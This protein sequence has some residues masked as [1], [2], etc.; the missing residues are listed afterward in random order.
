MTRLSPGLQQISLDSPGLPDIE[1][2]PPGGIFSH[3]NSTL[4]SNESSL[5]PSDPIFLPNNFSSHAYAG[6]LELNPGLHALP[7]PSLPPALPDALPIPNEMSDMLDQVLSSYT[8][9]Q[10]PPQNSLWNDNI[11]FE[12][13]V[14]QML[15]P[16]KP[17]AQPQ[18]HSNLASGPGFLFPPPFPPAAAASDSAQGVQEESLSALVSI[19]ESLRGASAADRRRHQSSD[20]HTHTQHSHQSSGSSIG[21]LPPLLQLCSIA[22][23]VGPPANSG[24]QYAQPLTYAVPGSDFVGAHGSAFNPMYDSVS[25]RRIAELQMQLASFSQ[26]FNGQSSG[27]DSRDRTDLMHRPI[28]FGAPVESLEQPVPKFTA[29]GGESLNGFQFMDPATAAAFGMTG[30]LQMP[31]ASATASANGAYSFS[32]GGPNAPII[33]Q[34]QHAYIN[35]ATSSP[36]ALQHLASV[37]QISPYAIPIPMPQGLPPPPPYEPSAL[38]CNPSAAT[39]SSGANVI[40]AELDASNKV[41]ST[42]P[43]RARSHHKKADGG[44]AGA[45]NAAASSQRDNSPAA[46]ACPAPAKKRRV[47]VRPPRG[48]SASV[49][50]AS[51]QQ[52]EGD[53]SAEGTSTEAAAAVVK[54]EP[55]SVDGAAPTTAL[56]NANGPPGPSAA[57]KRR[58]RSKARAPPPPS[59]FAKRYQIPRLNLLYLQ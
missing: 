7:D 6:E 24:P 50:P 51:S 39:S 28:S 26:N 59:P 33:I 37:P 41:S 3:I 31:G 42:T 12:E 5:F 10:N 22:D 36:V 58:R 34:P 21:Q 23:Q 4:L 16:F 8:L 19:D 14:A 30:P 55:I 17:T 46:D 29:A 57:N 1:E 45:A 47:R 15:D 2:S 52:A 40:K 32:F 25:Q 18:S 9:P 53:D 13:N 27:I 11:L 48:A 20:L 49:K 43:T 35:L 56:A 54:E 44:G 38:P